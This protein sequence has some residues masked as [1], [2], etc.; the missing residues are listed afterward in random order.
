LITSGSE[1]KSARKPSAAELNGFQEG[2]CAPRVEASN[3]AP[4][5]VEKGSKRILSAVEG[6][7]VDLLDRE[8]LFR[9]G[10]AIELTKSY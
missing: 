1:G 4:T 7:R 8:E 2:V 9:T 3:S 6:K 5:V 10:R